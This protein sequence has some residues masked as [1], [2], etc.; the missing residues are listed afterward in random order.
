MGTFVFVRSVISRESVA[1][2]PRDGRQAA[3]RG[4]SEGGKRGVSEGCE[5]GG[6]EGG[7]RGMGEGGK[8]AESAES[9][10]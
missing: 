5:R 3:Q 2:L 8:S 4:V 9:A 10:E 6:D 1:R 7:K